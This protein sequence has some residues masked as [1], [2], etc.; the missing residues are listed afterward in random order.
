MFYWLNVEIGHHATW[1]HLKWQS[2]FVGFEQVP[3][4]YAI[5]GAM[6]LSNTFASNFFT[7]LAIPFF[8]LW[9]VVEMNK[10]PSS[11]NNN[12]NEEKGKVEPEG[13]CGFTKQP[14]KLAN[15]LIRIALFVI[16]ISGCEVLSSAIAAC[17]LRRHLMAYKIFVPRLIFAVVSFIINTPLLIASACIPLYTLYR[18]SQW[19]NRSR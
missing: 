18:L 1:T 6:I 4:F 15:P 5:P 17:V 14:S 2:A 8:V 3:D 12:N 10:L 9:P 7:I 19:Q 16:A 13:E 11:S